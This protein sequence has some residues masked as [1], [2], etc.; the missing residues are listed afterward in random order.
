MIT[1]G[2]AVAVAV[3]ELAVFCGGFYAGVKLG[4]G[5]P[6]KL[7]AELKTDFAV[8]ESKATAD[9]EIAKTWVLAEIAKIKAKF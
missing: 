9:V 5:E 1:L 3:A 8:L 4:I 7:L 2:V 6:E